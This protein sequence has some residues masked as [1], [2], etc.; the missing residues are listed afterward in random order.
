MYVFY[1][2]DFD[3]DEYEELKNETVEQLKEMKESLAKMVK[4]DVTLVDSVN[5]MQ[6]VSQLISTGNMVN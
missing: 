6:L 5:A 3:D 2:D 4:G 1:R